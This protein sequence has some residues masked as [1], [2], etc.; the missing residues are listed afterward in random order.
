MTRIVCI[1]DTHGWGYRAQL[2]VPEGDVLVHAGDL[3]SRG[4]TYE[5]EEELNWFSRLPHRCKI[6]IAGNHD[7]L[8][9]QKPRTAREMIPASVT[10]LED[11]GCEVAGLRFW[12]SPVQP[13]FYDWAFNRQRGPEISKSWSKIPN[14]T[15]VL[16]TH[17]P[18]RGILDKTIDGRNDGCDDLLARI[19]EVQPKAHIFGHIHSGYG[20]Q[21]INGTIHINAAICT[22]E[23]QPINRPIVVDL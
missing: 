15:D 9:E 2:K 21:R 22:D 18:P 6:F 14:D 3:T 13:W 17:G 7:W 1:A 23:Y 16:V 19:R 10:Y 20:M 12:G 11:S 8:F 5:V 4:L